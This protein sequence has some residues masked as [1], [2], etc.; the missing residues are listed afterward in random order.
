MKTK[1][2]VQ[3]INETKSWF[4]EKISKVDTLVAKLKEREKTKINEIR[5]EKGDISH[6]WL[7]P[8][9]L[10]TQEAEIRRI[11]LKASPPPH[12]HTYQANSS[13]DPISENLIQNRSGV[14]AQMVE[15]LPRETSKHEALSSNPNTAKKKK[16][17]GGEEIRTN[18]NETQRI[19][20]KYF[21]MCIFFLLCGWGYIVEFTKFLI[22]YQMYHT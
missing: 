4:L 18:I 11:S 15:C 9:I 13:Q 17:V 21:E 12:T 16:N 14:V 5:D 19:I 8:V 10:A 6:R 20:K 3:R 22:M 2:I 1:R 7:M